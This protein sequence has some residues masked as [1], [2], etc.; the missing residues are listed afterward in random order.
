M[1][2][3]HIIASTDPESGGPVEALLRISEVLVRD[4]HEVSVVS[5][6]A[7]E[8]ARTR[9]F[10][11][12][13][14]G[15]GSGAG[16]YSY[17][18]RLTTWLRDHVRQF[19]AVVQHGLWNYSSLGMWLALKKSP[20]PYYVFVHGMMDPWFR[21]RYPLKHILK[22]IYWAAAEGRVLRDAA[23]VL[24]T[25]Q[26]E[27][28]CA[29]DA[30]YFHRYRERVV[31]LGTADPDG[32]ANAE[33]EA[34]KAACPALKHRKYLLFL[35]RVHPKKGCDLLVRA[36]AESAP[37]LPSDLDLV[38]AGPDQ[39]GWSAELQALS[40]QLGTGHRI[41]W[42]GML[43]GALKW[44]ALRGAEAL[45]L[46][47]HQENFGFVVAEAMACST[48][49]LISDK[50][51][52]WR[53]VSAAQAGLVQPDTFEGTKALIEKFHALSAEDRKR[54]SEDA[55]RGFLKHFDVQ[56]TAREFAAA[57][58]FDG[59]MGTTVHSAMREGAR[60]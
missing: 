51:N 34:F 2:L 44:G 29:T 21:Q 17:N 56:V 11:F 27:R 41:H 40:D 20:T 45:V 1:R 47:S 53:E 43:K 28:E 48:P 7:A 9:H 18:H 49:V 22:Q 58:G 52:I 38:I 39:V 8:D 35:G 54:M 16:K 55:R 15:I 42:P 31:P 32:D 57:I 26:N 59:Q 6:E 19:D 37:K 23:A 33:M 36:F 14:I 60:V 24:F 3:L 4:G 46:P 25:C 5:L 12:P 50:V 30:F 10:P 13:V